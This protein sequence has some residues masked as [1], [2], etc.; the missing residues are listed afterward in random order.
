MYGGLFCQWIKKYV[1]SHNFDF[2]P[3]LLWGGKKVRIASSD[4]SEL[5]DKK[6]LFYSIAVAKKKKK[7]DVN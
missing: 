5:W 7:Q 6:L 2:F 4:M 3:L 1:L